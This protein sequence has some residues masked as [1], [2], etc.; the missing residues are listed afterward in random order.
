MLKPAIIRTEEWSKIN[1][2]SGRYLTCHERSLM[3]RESIA[4]NGEK[5]RFCIANSGKMRK[6]LSVGAKT[7]QRILR[8]ENTSLSTAMQLAGELGVT[9]DSL[10]KEVCDDD[11]ARTVPEHWVY[12]ELQV[13]PAVKNFCP[14]LSLVGGG[15]D[16]IIGLGPTFIIGTL[17]DLLEHSPNDPRK[18]VLRRDGR[19]FIFELHR[20]D[21]D[22]RVKRGI[23]FG[24]A[25]ACRFYPVTRVDDKIEPFSL[26]KQVDGYVWSFLKRMA[27]EEAELLEVEGEE[28]PESPFAYLPLVRFFQ[29][30]L[31][32]KNMAGAR[33]YEQLHGDF[34]WA[35]VDYIDSL[36]SRRRVTA[37]ACGFGLHITI[38]PEPPDV[39]FL[40]WRENV[41]TL[42]VHLVWRTAS[43]KLRLAPWRKKHRDK[44]SNAINNRT[45]SDL[46]SR[47]MPL[48]YVP[49]DCEDLPELPMAPDPCFFDDDANVLG[50]L[51]YDDPMDVLWGL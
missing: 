34:R 1:D 16:F 30:P 14:F 37:R 42:V 40:G 26:S 20:F 12:G 51:Y 25:T 46:H 27:A 35:L 15:R 50:A 39:W 24:L 17:K 41:T 36:D 2:K 18:I 7:L 4:L 45:W 48:M 22:F 47:G 21:Y 19:A 10:M 6:Q 9:L 31:H 13:P 5:V 49:D 38:T 28:W 8:G 44:C 43:G 23:Y 29:D 32:E 33:L 11:L 3:T